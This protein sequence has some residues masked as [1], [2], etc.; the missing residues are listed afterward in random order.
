[1]YKRFLVPVDGSRTSNKALVAA[2]Q[3]ARDCGGDLRLLHVEDELASTGMSEHGVDQMRHLLEV[4]HAAALKVVD[5]ALA[6]ARAAGVRADHL[7]VAT[8]GQ[9]LGEVVAREATH[10]KADLIVLGSHGRRGIGRVLLGSGA[11]QIARLAPVPVLV[12]RSDPQENAAG[13]SAAAQ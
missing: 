13:G 5:D 8:A 2:L 6:I 12:I 11:E 10:W 9:R 1:M 4:G 3:M 7:V